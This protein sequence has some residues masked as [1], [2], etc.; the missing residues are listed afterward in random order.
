[1]SRLDIRLKRAYVTPSR[2]DGVRVLVDRLWPRGVL[3]SDVAIDLWLKELAPSTKLRQ[4]FGHDPG[5]W[6]EFRRRYQSELAG[7]TALLDELR[8]I[9]RR[10]SL[11]LVFAARDE[12]HNQAVVL[13]DVLTNGFKA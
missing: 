3:K 11:T 2:D 1:M 10:G 4:W 8:A 5:R 6:D 12:C 7:K 9:A 13:R